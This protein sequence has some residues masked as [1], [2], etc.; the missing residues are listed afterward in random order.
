MI[1]GH[2]GTNTGIVGCTLRH[3]IASSYYK[4]SSGVW[5]SAANSAN[6]IDF[7]KLLGSNAAHAWSGTDLKRT[8][9]D[10][11]LTQDFIMYMGNQQ[12][13]SFNGHLLITHSTNGNSFIVRME[14]TA[15]DP[16][17]TEANRVADVGTGG[18]TLKYTSSSISSWPGYT[19]M[20][21]RQQIGGSAH[22]FVRY[23]FTP[24]WNTNYNNSINLGH[25]SMLA[26]YGSITRSVY[27]NQDGLANFI[28]GVKLADSK[29]LQLGNGNDLEI[30]HNGV[31]SY[32]D[33]KVGAMYF[34]EQTTDGNMVFAADRGDGGG[35]YDYFYLDGGTATANSMGVTTAAYIKLG[36]KTRLDLQEDEATIIKTAGG[37]NGNYPAITVESSGTADSGAAIA[38]Q[39]KTSEGDTIIFADYEPHVEWGISAENGANEIHFTGGN[40]TGGLGS[41]TFKNNA[42]NDRTAYKKMTFNLGTGSAEIGALLTANEITSRSGVLNLDDNGD[43]DGVINAKASLTIN[44]DADNNSTGEAFRINRNTTTVNSTPLLQISESM[45][46]RFNAQQNSGSRI[47]LFNNRQDQS[48]VEVF[49]IASYNS[50]EASGIHFYRGGGGNSGYATVYAKKSNA[51]SLER[52]VKFGGDN[53][54]DATFA[55]DVIAYSD[56][57]VKENIKTLDGKKVLNMRG[58][59]FNRTDQDGRLSSGVIAQELEKVAPELVKDDGDLK[60]VAYGN[61]TGYLI[62]AIKDQQKQID[63]LKKLIKNGNNL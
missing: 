26:S 60:A 45:V 28:G 46:T 35:T 52:V 13:Y 50:I 25:M 48:N 59:S 21:I 3:K 7:N 49:R 55:A 19:N 42:G 4:N 37:A 44:I 11:G 1:F 53:T 12:G 34:R 57:R 41:K 31:H 16:G 22:A 14:T 15:T 32:I 24:T 33:N 29:K 9:A 54:L 6:Y 27:F 51:A 5:Q 8:G 20:K 47:E 10:S 63:E 58:V 17:I 56:K 43:A 23:R 39:Q 18:W 40:T 2:N 30:Y 38:I 61:L 62:E 36:N